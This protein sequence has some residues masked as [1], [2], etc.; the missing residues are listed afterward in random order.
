MNYAVILPV[1]NPDEKFDRVVDS[2]REAGF[3]QIMIID[4]GSDADHQIH[5][6][7]AA[8]FPECEVLHHNS[9]KGKGRSCTGNGKRNRKQ[10]VRYQ[11]QTVEKEQPYEK[12]QQKDSGK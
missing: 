6:E 9:N 2:L 12:K 3:R 1:L 4:D 8:V 10:D 7:R 11:A 5:F